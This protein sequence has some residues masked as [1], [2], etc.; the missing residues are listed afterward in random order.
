MVSIYSKYGNV[1]IGKN[2]LIQ[3]NVILGN[4]AE[5]PV[6]IG[7]NALIRSGSIIYSNVKIGNDFRTGHGILIREYSEIGDNVLIGTNTVI[8]GHCKLGNNISIQ[9]DAYI[10]AYTTIEDNVFIG[11]RVVTANDKYML[12]GAKLIGPT[13]KRGARI[14]A[15]ATILPGVIIGEEAIVGSGA[16]VTRDVPPG[17]TVIG[18]PARVMVKKNGQEI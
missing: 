7:N 18:N 12:A 16:I 1:I 6:I 17:A 3:E 8:D 11:P 4:S 10:T 5:G 15:N 14:G 9:T 13:I 2:Y